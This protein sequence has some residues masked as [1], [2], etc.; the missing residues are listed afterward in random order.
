MSVEDLLVGNSAD[1]EPAR[2]GFSP[3][4]GVRDELM[5][6][7]DEGLLVGLFASSIEGELSCEVR[8]V[9]T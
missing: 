8:G 6:Y 7:N 3:V 9:S 5:S 1:V 2:E 4:R